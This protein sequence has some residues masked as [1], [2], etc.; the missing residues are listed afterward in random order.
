MHLHYIVTNI[1][2][3]NL[4]LQAKLIFCVEVGKRVWQYHQCR[5]VFAP[6]ENLRVRIIRQHLPF[7]AFQHHSYTE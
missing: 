4:V 7:H 5:L 6:R 3:L 1:H 2:T